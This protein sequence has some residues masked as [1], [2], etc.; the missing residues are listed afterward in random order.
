MRNN[1]SDASAIGRGDPI[2]GL[3]IA[4]EGPTGVLN[5]YRMAVGRPQVFFAVAANLAD[6]ETDPV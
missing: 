1:F 3:E 2:A 4:R 5:E 6:A